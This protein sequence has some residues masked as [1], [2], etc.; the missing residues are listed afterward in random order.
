M[1]DGN[2]ARDSSASTMEMSVV[3]EQI[4]PLAPNFAFVK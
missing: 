2:A 1:N 3:I 4:F